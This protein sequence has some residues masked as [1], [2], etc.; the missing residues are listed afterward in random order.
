MHALCF[1]ERGSLHVGNLVFGA[2]VLTCDDDAALGADVVLDVD[3]ALDVRNCSSR[4]MQ[5]PHSM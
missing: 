5:I 4:S 1:S 3:T 2:K